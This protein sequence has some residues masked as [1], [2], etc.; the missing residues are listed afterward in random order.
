MTF[1]NSKIEN[2]VFLKILSKCLSPEDMGNIIGLKVDKSWRIGDFRGKTKIQERMN[3]VVIGSRLDKSEEL[4]N[5]ILDLFNR[6]SGHEKSIKALSSDNSVELS[7]AVYAEVVPALYFEKEVIR[8]ISE[9]GA[10]FDIDLYFLPQ[11]P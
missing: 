9:I 7:C 11:S 8:K 5:H 10:S 3:G 4:E 2:H 1:D 6:I